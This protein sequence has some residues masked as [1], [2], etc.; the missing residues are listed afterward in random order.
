[1]DIL[2]GREWALA[3]ITAVNII[4]CVCIVL[5]VQGDLRDVKFGRNTNDEAVAMFV[6]LLARAK[7][8]VD[9]H[10]DG[11]DFHESVYNDSRVVDA[12]GDCLKRNVKIRCLF[13]NQDRTPKIL[14]LLKSR[15]KNDCMQV[16]YLIGERPHPDTPYK[17][18]DGG[19][20]LHLSNHDHGD[21]E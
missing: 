14:S 4:A 21:D 5:S 16:W 6:Y 1:M 19:R 17:I 8:S 12:I 2:Q 3:V 15:D 20:Y 9:I 10:D 18:V 11:N 13:N 7:R